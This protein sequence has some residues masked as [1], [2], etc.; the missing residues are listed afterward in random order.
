MS[1]F[2]QTDIHFQSDN[3]MLT[4]TLHLPD[5][6]IKNPPCIIGS[7]GLF[8][9]AS[10]PKQIALSNECNIRNM[11]YFRFDHR[12]CGRSEG[13]FKTVTTIRQRFQDFRDAIKTILNHPDTGNKVGFFGSS[14]GGSI[15]LLAGISYKPQAIVTLSAPIS[16]N[17]VWEVL[18]QNK[19][20]QLLSNEFYQEALEFDILNQLSVINHTL[21]FHGSKDEVVPLA[22]ANQIYEHVREPKKLI[23]L[24]GGCHRL[25]QT[26][27]Q[28]TFM[29]NA[30]D[31]FEQY[32]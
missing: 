19:Q 31:W 7:H 16:M 10:S 5:S 29:K 9:D 21:I 13:I 6:I 17:S 3:L 24:D 25:S 18:I 4:G 2:K 8:S 14:L 12:G 1:K 23:V 11:A 27:H 32:L 26:H 15:A 30:V 28:N 20:D 22:N